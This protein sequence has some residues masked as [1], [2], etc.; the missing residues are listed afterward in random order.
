[1]W[2]TIRPGQLLGQA[3]GLLRTWHG[4]L[5]RGLGVASSSKNFILWVALLDSRRQLMNAAAA[6]ADVACPL[7]QLSKSQVLSCSN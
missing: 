7:Q 4:F 5:V 2:C 3:Q 1:M 6:Y